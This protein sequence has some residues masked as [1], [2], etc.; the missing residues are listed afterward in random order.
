LTSTP[1]P[2]PEPAQFATH[3]VKAFFT[4]RTTIL[5]MV[6]LT[7][8][9]VLAVSRP[10]SF[11]D[12]MNFKAVFSLMI[13]DLLLA[14]GMT[15]ILILGGIDLSVGSVMALVSVVIALSLKARFNLP[16]SL[17]LG[18]V[19]AVA[20]GLFNGIATA[21]FRIAPFLI[22]LAT[23]SIAR[24]IATV[25]TTG[26]YVSFPN[27]DYTWFG[28]WE[29][30]VYKAGNSNYSIPMILIITLLL[31]VIF[32]I[33]IKKWKPLNQAFF[34][35]ANRSAAE[36]SG[37]N[38][39]AVMIVGYIICALFCF[40]AAAFMT[41]NNRIGYANYGIGAEMRAIAAAIVGGC[42]MAGGVGSMAGTFLGV[43]MLALI[44][45]GFILLNGSPN[46]Q[47][48]STGI[49]LILAVTVDA[50]INRN[51]RKD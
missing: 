48:A 6:N 3:P 50:I 27:R 32:D 41:A 16:L 35:G 19:T 4:A 42:S 37:I 23:M 22:T 18:F 24:G 11:L 36:M 28:R 7:I 2:R 26:Q 21:R 49:I 33:L 34:I 8:F 51:R 45:N 5:L 30:V 46:W 14:G 15:Y 47:Q 12:W 44:A 40:I 17:F 9:L 31:F 1:L 20:C 38:V 10:T 43:T 29:L 25:A 13:Y 39:N